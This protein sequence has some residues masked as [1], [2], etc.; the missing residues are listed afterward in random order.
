MNIDK[1]I[2]NENSP[3]QFIFLI[4]SISFNMLPVFGEYFINLYLFLFLVLEE[5]LKESLNEKHTRVQ[6]PFQHF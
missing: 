1:K 5:N 2:N 4:L 3:Y 6:C